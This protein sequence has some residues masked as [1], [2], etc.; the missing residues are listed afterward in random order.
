MILPSGNFYAQWRPQSAAANFLRDENGSPSERLLQA[1]WQHQR[2]RRDQLKTA[3]GKTVR[4]FH[5]GFIS[6]EGGPDF[7]GAIL[8]IG[9][10]AP[11]S[12]DVEIDLRSSRL[13][14]ARPRQK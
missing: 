7:C 13:A 9:D 1:V 11:H 3:D 5:P 2:L 14:R 4:I 6:V 8:Q 12:G 10:D